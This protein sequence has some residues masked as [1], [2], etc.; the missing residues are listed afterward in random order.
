[1]ICSDKQIT[2]QQ[3]FRA[4]FALSNLDKIDVFG[5]IHNPI[6]KKEE[7]LNDYM[8]SVCIENGTYDTYF[9]EKLLDAF[10][11]GTI[12]IYKGTRNVVNHF[13]S[14]GILFL[15]DINIDDLTE[16]LYYSKLDFVKE[17][18][19]KVKEL[20]I[21]ENWMYKNYLKNIL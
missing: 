3:R 18:F 1:M 14:E 16:D 6:Q 7:G 10:A 9:T 5:H 21:L 2:E 13:N 19:E 12:P 15:D 11:T 8:F 17:N 20:D 4:S